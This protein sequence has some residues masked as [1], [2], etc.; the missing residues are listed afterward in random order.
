MILLIQKIVKIENVGRFAKLTSSGDVIFRKL[1]L[2]YGENGHGKTTV[3]GI[4]RSLSTGDPAY[5]AERATLGA[6]GGQVVHIL[7]STNAVAK[8]SGGT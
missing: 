5:L 6:V 1:T 8:F 2:L 4:L 3:A 7:L